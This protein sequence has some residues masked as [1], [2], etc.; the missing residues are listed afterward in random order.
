MERRV[1][2]E[3]VPHPPCPRFKCLV[4]A[5]N[6]RGTVTYCNDAGVV[7]AC[8]NNTVSLGLSS[9]LNFLCFVKD[10]CGDGLGTWRRTTKFKTDLP[11]WDT[12]DS[13][14]DLVT[15]ILPP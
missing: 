5:R 13:D 15:S 12:G 14:F 10:S 4:A 11:E 7:V 1:A 9:K 3:D 8:L 6:F 2:G